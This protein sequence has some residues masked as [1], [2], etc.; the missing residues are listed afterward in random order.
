MKIRHLAAAVIVVLAAAGAVAGETE[1]VLTADGAVYTVDGEAASQLVLEKR[2]DDQT[3]NILV[4]TTDDPEMDADARLLWDA[5]SSRLYVIW[6]RYS[7][8]TDQIV[9]AT[10]SADG[11]WSDP[12]IV[13]TGRNST[14]T[15]LTAVLSRA[16]IEG[17]VVTFLHAA[18]WSIGAEQVAQYALV[19]FEGIEHVSSHVTDLEALAG[20]LA[21]FADDLEPMAE[22]EHPPLA[23]TRTELGGVEVVFGSPASTRLTRLLIDVKLSP[24]ARLWKPSRASGGFT[25]RASIQSATGE[26]VRTILNRGRIV[27]YAPERDFRFVIYDRG[28][29]TPERMIRLDERLTREQLVEQLR[30]VV[31]Q[32]DG[33]EATPGGVTQ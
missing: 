24:N 26:P 27:L 12:I 13:A 9:L 1:A 20:D 8:R 23:M 31:E 28:R 2:V 14:R 4:P 3:T 11:T 15:G 30:R 22:V 33:E 25:P 10:M 16:A 29:W 5:A 32:L 18:W 17:R 19:A 7:D 6:H 21:G